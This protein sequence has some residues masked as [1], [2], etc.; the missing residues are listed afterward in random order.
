[1]SE[2]LEKEMQDDL[3]FK[4]LA[5]SDRRKILD[6]L[7][8]APK[9]TGDICQCLSWLSRCSVMQHLK[10]LAQAGLIISQKQGRH[11]WNYLDVAPIQGIYHRWIKAHASSAASFLHVL[12]NDIENSSD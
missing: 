10:V 4:A 9:T 11:S 7:K 12:K 1:M 5:A 6:L 3:V 2:Y 8:D